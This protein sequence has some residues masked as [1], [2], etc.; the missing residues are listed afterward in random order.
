MPEHEVRQG[1]CILSIANQTGHHWETIWNAP[2]NAELKQLRERPNV[3]LPGDRVHVPD[4]RLEQ[5]SCAT[6][7]RHRFRR[8][9]EPVVLR[10]RFLSSNGEPRADESYQINVDGLWL[11]GNLDSEGQLQVPLPADA[12]SARVLIGQGDSQDEYP[13]GLR[14]LDPISETTGIQQRLYNLG[15]NCR[16]TGRQDRQTEDALKA[17]QSKH[18]I[19]ESGSPDETTRN[20][21]KADHSNV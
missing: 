3:L 19:P 12:Q 20:G 21:L 4:I 1:E 14:C 8:C 16:V 6:G 5:G 11:S 9:G 17:F 15:F 2:E 13:L 7:Q 18:D 10:I